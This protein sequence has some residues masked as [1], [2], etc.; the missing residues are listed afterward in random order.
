MVRKVKLKNPLAKHQTNLIFYLTQK[1]YACKSQIRKTMLHKFL[2][3]K[4]RFNKKL[5]FI[6]LIRKTGQLKP[7]KVILIRKIRLYAQL[8][9]Q[10]SQQTRP[11]QKIQTLPL[12]ILSTNPLL[13]N[14]QNQL[15]H[16]R[17]TLQSH[18]LSKLPFTIARQFSINSKLS[19][20][21]N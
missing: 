6:G 4:N 1:A 12:R 15:N 7:F 19:Q 14:Y 2:K 5:A 16:V 8:R 13:N 11:K 10:N 18:S 3:R 20:S 9:S 17:P 21:I